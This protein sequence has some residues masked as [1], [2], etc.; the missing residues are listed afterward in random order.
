DTGRGPA[1]LGTITRVSVASDGTQ[2]DDNSYGVSVSGDGTLVAFSSAA[3]NLV[4][5]DRNAN[6]DVFLYDRT[7]SETTRASLAS[8]NTE[9]NAD[10]NDPIVTTDGKYVVFSSTATNLVPTAN[11]GT[12]QIFSRWLAAS[13]TDHRSRGAFDWVSA[14]AA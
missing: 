10:C 7:R 14:P 5:F 1:S 13:M 11:A 6:I 12:Q 9:P 8:D 4:L 2:G 3:T